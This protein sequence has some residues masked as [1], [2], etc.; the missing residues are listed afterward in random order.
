[1]GWD[2][3]LTQLQFDAWREWFAWQQEQMNPNAPKQV[4]EKNQ[5]SSE[6]MWCAAAG[7]NLVKRKSNE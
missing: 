7:P 3:P 4:P 1:M 2:G 6:Q 5:P